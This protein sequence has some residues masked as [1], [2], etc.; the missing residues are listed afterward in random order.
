MVPHCCPWSII[1]YCK[2]HTKVKFMLIK[3]V[4]VV[5]VKIRSFFLGGE[6]FIP[7]ENWIRVL[8][9]LKSTEIFF[10][11]WQIIF[12][13]TL[14]EP[15]RCI[16]SILPVESKEYPLKIL[17]PEIY[18]LLDKIHHSYANWLNAIFNKQTYETKW[19]YDPQ[20]ILNPKG[21]Y[22]KLQ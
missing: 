14:N 3:L 4:K 18:T 11:H 9:I 5:L 19:C 7:T 6:P 12:H 10:K 2:F 13:H 15:I 20:D 22:N 17:W 8:N 1:K 21:H 16:Y